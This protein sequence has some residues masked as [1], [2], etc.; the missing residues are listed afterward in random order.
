MKERFSRNKVNLVIYPRGSSLN[1]REK[2]TTAS[3]VLYNSKKNVS[4]GRTTG[5]WVKMS[6]GIWYQT[7][8]NGVD[9]IAWVR[10]DVIK[11]EKPTKDL[12][13]SKAEV[14]SIVNKLVQND[15]K[16]HESLLRSSALIESLKKQ[17][18]SFSIYEKQFKELW[19]RME[20]RQD[21][22]KNSR[23]V[24]WKEGVK[25]W[26]NQFT[27]FVK[28]IFKRS[29]VGSV[30]GASIIIGVV[31]IALLNGAAWLIFRPKYINSTKDLKISGELESLLNQAN[32]L[33]AERIKEDLERQIDQAFQTGVS[34]G[35]FGGS[36]KMIKN[37][38]IGVGTFLVLD[39]GMR[40][41][42][43]RKK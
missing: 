20:S 25:N 29:S 3:R 26:Y 36:L 27:G 16:V 34:R 33:M 2:P 10:E 14:Q 43:K 39:W 22:I 18:R 6:D 40:K 32:P 7:V 23:A 38:A 13:K 4:F 41:M 17:G 24:R 5:T 19:D 21:A 12:D 28:N 37:L 31:V 1:Y 15:I 30:S 35:E 42:E 11:L 8:L 9:K